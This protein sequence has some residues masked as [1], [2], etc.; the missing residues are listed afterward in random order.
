MQPSN[1]DLNHQTIYWRQDFKDKAVN[2]SKQLSKEPKHEEKKIVTSTPFVSTPNTSSNEETEKSELPPMASMLN[3]KQLKFWQIFDEYFFQL[4]KFKAGFGQLPKPLRI[5]VR[6]GPGSGKTFLINAITENLEQ[7]GFSQSSCALTKVAS[8][9][10]PDKQTMHKTFGFKIKG[11]K[12]DIKSL[13]ELTN[14]QL[15]NLR[16]RFD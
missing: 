15:F 2:V 13:A 12:T 4:K 3:P 9:N 6:G 16:A 10:L 8:G 14:T 1:E 7:Y 11:K 5:F